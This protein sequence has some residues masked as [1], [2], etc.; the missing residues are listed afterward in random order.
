MCSTHYNSATEALETSFWFWRC[1][2]RLGCVETEVNRGNIECVYALHDSALCPRSVSSC[3]QLLHGWAAVVALRCFHFTITWA[4]GAG[5]KFTPL[6]GEI[7]GLWLCHIES[8]SAPRSSACQC[9]STE[10]AGCWHVTLFIKATVHFVLLRFEPRTK[11]SH[12]CVLGLTLLI[13]I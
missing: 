7:A 5:Q 10:T 6:F 1:F 11:R 8:L 12:Y 13:A 4:A 9:L 2:Q 3:C